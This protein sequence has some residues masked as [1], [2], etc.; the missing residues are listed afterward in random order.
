[1][2]D[3]DIIYHR[4][5][6]KE[7]LLYRLALTTHFPVSVTIEIIQYFSSLYSFDVYSVK[8][9]FISCTRNFFIFLSH[10]LSFFFQPLNNV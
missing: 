1:M 4:H 9:I 10:F 2:E 8:K 6:H 7:L 5:H 3:L